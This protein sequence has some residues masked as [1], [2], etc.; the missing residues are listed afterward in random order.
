LL[1][2][3]ALETSNWNPSREAVLEEWCGNSDGKACERLHQALR[4][5]LAACLRVES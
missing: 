3:P 4:M 2:Q 5:E 1:V